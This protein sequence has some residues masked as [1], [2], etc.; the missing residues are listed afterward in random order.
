MLTEKLQQGD[1]L[2]KRLDGGSFQY[3]FTLT[4]DCD[5][6]NNKFRNIITALPIISI[7]TYIEEVFFV[8]ELDKCRAHYE[9]QFTSLEDHSIDREFFNNHILPDDPD[10]VFERYVEKTAPPEYKIIRAYHL[11]EIP[12]KDAFVQLC[13]SRKASVSKRIKSCLKNIQSDFFLINTLPQC[14]D[15]GFLVDL[16]RPE[17]ISASEI[18]L[19][20]AAMHFKH[21]QF[22]YFRLGSMPDSIRFALSQSFSYLFSRIGIPTEFE[23][24]RNHIIELFEEKFQ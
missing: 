6:Y 13:K 14:S 12:S 20:R 22:I 18:S 21:S 15:F 19:D 1:I 2:A 16:R 10:S 3:Y 9:D 4:P 24:E 7:E 17:S 8:S 5:I 23:I 11:E